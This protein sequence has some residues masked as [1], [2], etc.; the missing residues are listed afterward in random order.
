MS[1]SLN[2]SVTGQTVVYD[3]YNYN[4][5][6]K[7]TKWK[8]DV[9]FGIFTFLFEVEFLSSSTYIKSIIS[10]MMRHYINISANL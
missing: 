3:F 2:H 8:T 10:Q 4:V 5:I 7:N 9:S 1:K 6:E